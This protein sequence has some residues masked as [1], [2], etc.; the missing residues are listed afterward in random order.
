MRHGEGIYTFTTF[1]TDESQVCY[2]GSWNNNKKNGIGMQNY[3]NVG[4]YHGYWENGE[5]HGE[6]V[7]KYGNNDVYSGQWANGCKEGKGTY[8]FFKTGQKYT[9]EWRKGQMVNGQWF[10]P[11]GTF[12]SGNF[13]NNMPKGAGQWNFKDG[14]KVQGCYK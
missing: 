8:I 14:N 12:F 7:L 9:G 11:N 2:K 6:G 4:D 10:Y 3:P 13:D 1:C 5:R